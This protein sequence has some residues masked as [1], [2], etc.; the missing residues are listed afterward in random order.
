MSLRR[1]RR[2]S[3]Q[4][5]VG[6]ALGLVAGLVGEA[7]EAAAQP[8]PTDRIVVRLDFGS[9]PA[10]RTFAATRAF[11][12]FSEQ[13]VFQAD[14]EIG[15]GGLVDGGVSFLIWRNLA[16]GLDVSSYRSSNS[17]Q[18]S[19]EVPH[20]FF[21][22]LP[23][24]T[25]GVAGGLVRDELGVHV[26]AMWVM[27]LA[28]WLVVSASAG[29]SLINA[30]Q[31]LVAS[32]EHTEVG[33]PFDDLIF[34]GHTVTAQSSNT[35]GVNA[36]VDIDT[37]VLHRLPFL[38]RYAVLERVGIGLLLRYVRGSVDVQVGDD[39]VDVDLGGFQVTT[40]LRFRF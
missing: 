38:N 5:A 25:T 27:Q 11:P 9:R 8:A 15:G 22:D 14:Y 1:R 29:P 17:A 3:W 40:G 10:S 2:T 13:G 7:P 34:T 21:F 16:V 33:F 32:V 31:D 35:V 12:V 24:T 39:P 37:F 4:R 30:Q 26:R 28:D 19:S 36:G 20:P 18:L 23:R 6:V